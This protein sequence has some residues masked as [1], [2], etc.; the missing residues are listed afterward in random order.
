MKWPG[1]VGSSRRQRSATE[2]AV[3][4]RPTKRRMARF[5]SEV[6][7][8][9]NMPD[10]PETALDDKKLVFIVGSPRGGT[11]WLQGLLSQAPFVS[12][13]T[14]THIFSG[15][16]RSASE[17]WSRLKERPIGLSSVF[18]DD[19]FFAWY[20]D[21][22]RFWLRKLGEQTPD[23]RVFL[24]KTP[25]H[26]AFGAQ[27]LRVFPKSYFIHI[28]RDPRSVAASL[29]AASQSWAKAWAP[30]AMIDASMMWEN[31]VVQARSIASLTDRYSEIN[32]ERLHAD[33]ATETMGLFEW[34]GEPI[35]RAEAETYVA[36]AAFDKMRPKAT[37]LRKRR[38]VDK[39][40]YRRGEVDSWRRELSA[41]EIAIVERLTRKQMAQLGYEPIAARPA[42]IAAAA[43]LG[44][45]G[46]AD[47]LAKA[48]RAGA[49]WIKP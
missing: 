23:A 1:E 45:Y 4:E 33:G 5:R 15:Y 8:I 41:T 25:R 39:Q 9:L 27:I 19:E 35:G 10:A 12:T 44:A 47:K 42:R 17:N 2:I 46:A 6:V 26:S 34:L 14:E 24:E 31:H 36:A 18:S 21:L 16:L 37:A 3:V 11:T 48:V 22:P 30:G 20:G 29:R 43:R 40:F 13:T 28:I 7:A 32:Y 49:D 38:R